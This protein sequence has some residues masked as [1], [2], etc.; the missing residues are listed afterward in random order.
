MNASDLQ[1]PLGNTLSL[2]AFPFLLLL[3]F[4]WQLYQIRKERIEHK[5]RT[6]RRLK[7]IKE[8]HHNKKGQVEP[9]IYYW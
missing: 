7:A 1:L 2:L 4:I 8:A 6:R 3:F 9:G 5:N